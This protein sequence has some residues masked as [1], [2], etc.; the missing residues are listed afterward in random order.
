MSAETKGVENVSEAIVMYPDLEKEVLS[1][2]ENKEDQ[3]LIHRAYLMAY[4]AHQ[5]QKRKS[6]EDYIHHPLA[7]ALILA[8][9]KSSP[10][11]ICAG[12]LHDVIEDTEITYTDV[13]EQFGEP[14]ARV[15]QGVT[16]LDK[17]K[18]QVGEHAS[19]NYQNLIFSMI[20]DVTVIFVKLA[21]RLHNM[22]TLGSMPPH[23]QERIARETLDILV[24]IA[25]RLGIYR[26]KSELEDL[27]L[28]VLDPERYYHIVNRLKEKRE[29]R[30]EKLNFMT[31]SLNH[32]L[33]QNELRFEVKGRIKNI[34]SIY[35]KMYQKGKDFEEIYDLSALRILTDTI[36][37][38]YAILGYIHSEY[39]PLPS[40]IKDYIAMP[41]PN[42]YQSL[43]TT[44][45]SKDGTIYEIQIR[46]YAMESI[47]EYGVA[48]HWTYK[49]SLAGTQ[50]N[51]AK[52][53]QQIKLFQEIKELMLETQEENSTVF[54]DSL[55]SDVL[56]A[57]IYVFTPSGDVVSL[58]TG[59]TPIDFAYRVHTKVG[60]KTSGAKVN[61]RI[62]PLGY[63]LKTGDVVEILTQA[64]GKPKEAWL[65]IAKTSSA[66]SK[67]KQYFKKERREEYLESG[68]DRLQEVLDLKGKTIEEVL[69][70]QYLNDIFDKYSTPTF[71]DLLV[72]FGNKT[73]SATTVANRLFP[74]KE[75]ID[76]DDIILQA[77]N[78]EQRKKRAQSIVTL[79][80]IDNISHQFAKCCNPIFGDE[81]IG[82]I[83]QSKGLVIHRLD[84]K[85]L[86]ELD[87]QRLA[88]VTW[89]VSDNALTRF[90]IHLQV[91]SFDRDQ[92]LNDIVQVLYR[93]KADIR[94]LNSI[95]KEDDAT[96][97]Q[98]TL[99][100]TG[101]AQTREIIKQLE[102]ISGV[103]RVSRVNAFE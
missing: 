91:Q 56:S 45:L 27:S 96:V 41:K 84:C 18:V 12:L 100:V 65:R 15:V 10:S 93:M 99:S 79:G 97:T 47:A 1:Y 94:V 23:K 36:P 3:Q 92:L 81:I 102:R 58:P 61:D 30:L 35:K 52:Q 34:Y 7:V 78:N 82:Y 24:P 60:D 11:V 4:E 26:V 2:I 103:F 51:K 13:L 68:R 42:G 72:A 69:E 86:H 66:R 71:E 64:N 22:R 89:S 67:I 31:D 21:D 16:K 63:T 5:G 37:N 85:T 49:D 80:E 76:L 9:L 77:K 8:E 28:R 44:V 70:H 55:K 101:V 62:V 54:I 19:A 29:N 87:A 43:H 90:D 73:V 17:M 98:L 25:H 33:A 40:R 83:S 39:T 50:Q 6:G 48:A 20:D 53:N 74:D 95:V 88:D 59:S 32:I 57:N 75:Q 38:C 14:I 46:T